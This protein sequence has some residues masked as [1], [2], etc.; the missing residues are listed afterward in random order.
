MKISQPCKSVTVKDTE[1]RMRTF[2]VEN[3]ILNIFCLNTFFS[4]INIYK[5]VNKKLIF[6]I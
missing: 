6:G 3:S 2:F 5:D 4:K 1:I